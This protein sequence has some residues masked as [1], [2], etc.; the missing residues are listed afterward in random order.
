MPPSLCCRCVRVPVRLRVDGGGVGVVGR[1]L[2]VLLRLRTPCC[3]VLLLACRICRSA[4][5]STSMAPCAW[6]QPGVCTG[7]LSQVARVVPWRL[8]L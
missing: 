7:S 1:T 4:R 3:R 2:G 5:R 6:M 8:V